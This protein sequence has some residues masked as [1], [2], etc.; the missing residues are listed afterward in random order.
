VERPSEG[1]LARFRSGEHPPAGGP[2]C[3]RRQPA[4][5]SQEPDTWVASVRRAFRQAACAPQTQNVP[6]AAGISDPGYS[7]LLSVIVGRLCE[8]PLPANRLAFHRNALQIYSPFLR[9]AGVAS[10]A[11]WALEWP[12][13]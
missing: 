12:W 1:G 7:Y 13:V 9:G 5:D 4:D 3:R 10:V 11:A 2:A 8:T 6:F